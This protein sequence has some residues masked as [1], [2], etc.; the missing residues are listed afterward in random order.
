MLGV[1]HHDDLYFCPFKLDI[2]LVLFSLSDENVVF[3][4]AHFRDRPVAEELY[5]WEQV[6]VRVPL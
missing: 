3:N 6:D 2:T 4:S 1:A 5:I